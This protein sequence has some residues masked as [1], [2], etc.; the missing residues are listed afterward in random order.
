MY[1]ASDISVAITSNGDSRASQ[2]TIDQSL[3]DGGDV[4]VN[5]N[6]NTLIHISNSIISHTVN[7]TNG[8]VFFGGVI[9]PS[10]L[11]FVTFHSNLGSVGCNSRVNFKNN[12]VVNDQPNPPAD[13]ASN[14]CSHSHDLVKPQ[15]TAL[16]PSNLLNIDPQ[17]KDPL[18]GDLHIMVGSPAINAADPG[19]TNA[20]DFDGNARPGPGRTIGAYE[21]KP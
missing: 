2:V 13:A 7:T 14:G 10:S 15:S 19:A 20:I 11:E 4:A 12:I 21:F 3:I 6:S 18:H 16:G 8:P 9:Q 1:A 17:F 5:L